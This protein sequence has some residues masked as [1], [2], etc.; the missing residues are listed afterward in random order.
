MATT[1]QI[2][3]DCAGLRPVPESEWND[4]DSITTSTPPC[5][6][7]RGMSLTFAER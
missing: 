3:F 6:I 4:G 5:A 7:P 1:V 2:T